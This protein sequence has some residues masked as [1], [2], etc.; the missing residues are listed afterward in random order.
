MTIDTVCSASLV[1]TQLAWMAL[2]VAECGTACVCG[3]ALCIS[4]E[5]SAIIGAAGMLAGDGRC[6][7]LDTTADGYVRAENV[8]VFGLCAPGLGHRDAFAFIAGAAVNQDGRSS[9][10]SAPNGPSQTSV[11]GASLARADLTADS[12]SALGMHGTGT[13]L[14]DPIEVGGMSAILRT[15]VAGQRQGDRVVPLTLVASKSSSGHG[16]HVAGMVR[17]GFVKFL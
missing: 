8:A 11:I 4:R 1:A 13:S 5:S 7:T 6:K 3:S 14:G 16:E 15:G 2:N 9:S 12:V 17:L 10:L